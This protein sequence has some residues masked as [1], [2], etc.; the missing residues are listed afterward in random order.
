MGLPFLELQS[1]D[2]TNNYARQQLSA[3]L[4]QHGTAVFAH[5]QT[6]GKGQRGNTWVSEKDANI[7]LSIVIKPYPLV[8]HQQFLLNACIVTAACE[9]F[10]NYAENETKIKWPNDLY[11]QNRKAGL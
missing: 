6:A 2:S 8:L 10:R 4:A 11:W 9:W 3:G 7:A 5:E 1:V